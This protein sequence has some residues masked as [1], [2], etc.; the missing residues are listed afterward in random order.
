MARRTLL[1]LSLAALL[2]GS[3]AAAAQPAGAAKGQP[4][5]P[6]RTVHV[7]LGQAAVPLYG[8]W[9]FTVGDSPI[10]PRTGQPL[11]AEPDFDDSK[12]ET[13]D[14]TPK[15]RAID[16]N[17]GLSGYVPGWTAKGHPGYWGYA[18]YRIK[19]RV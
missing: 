14:L 1:A 4:A 15:G 13:V 17:A 18:W 12:W 19:V 10:D 16:P 8:P 9:K 6:D 2:A 3:I 7:A 11:W 5:Q